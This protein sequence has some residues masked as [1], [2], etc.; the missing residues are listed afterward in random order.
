MKEDV[1]KGEWDYIHSGFPCGSF[2]MARHHKVPGEAEAVR[3][4][5]KYEKLYGLPGNSALQQREADKGT[6]MVRSASTS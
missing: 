3:D 6:R 1:A 5:K 2:S 4:K